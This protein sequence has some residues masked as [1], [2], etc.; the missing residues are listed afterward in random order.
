MLRDIDRNDETTGVKANVIRFQYPNYGHEQ[1]I[2]R[3][4][5]GD[6]MRCRESGVGVK[7]YTNRPANAA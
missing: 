7:I 3:L 1:M 2:G 5:Q 6:R 4:E